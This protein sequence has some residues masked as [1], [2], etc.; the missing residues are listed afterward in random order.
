MNWWAI[1]VV[2]TFIVTPLLTLTFLSKMPQQLYKKGTYLIKW[3]LIASG[4]EYL[5]YKKN[6][7][8]YGH[9]WSVFWSGFLYL[10]MFVYSYI[11]TIH[12]KKIVAL[13][14]CTTVFFVHKFRVPLRRK[15]YSKYFEPLVD[16]RY[17]TFLENLFSHT[18]RKLC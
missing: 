4:I 8:L 11:F 18:K 16:L 10:I 6:L 2:H 5:A 13:S 14:L 15:H 7:I 3:V 9:G 1:R 17:H 12:P